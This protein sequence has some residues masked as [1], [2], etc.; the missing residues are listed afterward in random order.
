[1]RSQLT[2]ILMLVA[3]L[4]ATGS[5]WDVVQVFAWGRM[6]AHNARVLP[7][8]D[9]LELTFSAQG[10]CQVCLTVQDNRPAAGEEAA[11]VSLLAKEPL[12]FQTVTGVVVAPPTSAAWIEGATSWLTHDRTAPPTPPPRARA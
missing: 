10:R 2:K 6:L 7:L 3:W 5:H 12:V 1:M 9:A 4:L 11:A 8:R